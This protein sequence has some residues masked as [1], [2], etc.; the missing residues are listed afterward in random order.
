MISSLESN[1]S[2]LISKTKVI[3]LAAGD[4]K[5][6][7]PLSNYITKPMLP[8]GPIPLLGH[9]MKNYERVGFREFIIV[10]SKQEELL[11]P[12][13]ERFRKEISGKIQ[14]VKQPKPMGM[15]DAVLLTKSV[16]TPEDFEKN[17]P[18]YLTAG[19]ILFSPESLLDLYKI[20]VNER[21]SMTLALCH[22]PD[23]SMATG[24]G[25]VAMDENKNVSRIVEKPGPENRVGDYY[26]VPMYV[27]NTSFFEYVEQVQPSKRGEKELQD[28]MQMLIDTKAKIVGENVVPKS[29]TVPE[30]GAYHL[31]YPRDF[32]AMNSRWLAE[33]PRSSKIGSKTYV[34][35]GVTIGKNVN[36]SGSYIF[37]NVT[38]ADNVTIENSVIMEGVTVTENQK[39]INKIKTAN[40]TFDLK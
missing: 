24:Y 21:S 28:A 31:T 15:A 16:F 29:I 14:L 10:Y 27:F 39:I 30:D 22:S 3:I 19:D 20:H 40:D 2:E 12:F 37:S 4:A 25:N 11:V 36:I 18:F 35:E 23:G 38:I 13:I 17:Y 1:I 7:A 32:L 8:I 26:S 6:M 33:N 34:G 9:I 5:R